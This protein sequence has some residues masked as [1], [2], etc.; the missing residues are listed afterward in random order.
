MMMSRF[1]A[2]DFPSLLVANATMG[3]IIDHEYLGIEYEKT[4][5]VLKETIERVIREDLR[6]AGLNVKYY[7]WTKINFNKD[8]TV[9]FS[10][11]SCA[12]TW[13]IFE[14]VRKERLLLLA[15]T[16]PDCPRLP[17]HEALTIPRIKIGVELPQILV[18]IRTSH[19]VNWKTAT[20]LYDDIFDRDT[21]SRVASSLSVESDSLAMSVSLLKLNSSTDLYERRENIKKS[22]ST[23]PTRSVGANFMVIATI[24]MTIIE[25]ATELNMINTASQWLF[26][27]SNPRKTNVTQLITYIKEGGNV[28]IATNNTIIDGSCSLGENCLYHE[29][30]KNFAMSLS[31]LVREEETIYS[32]ISDEEWESIRLTKRERRDNMLEFIKDR[33]RDVQQ[34]KPCVNWKFESAETWGLR[35][36]NTEGGK[37]K[38]FKPI[39]TY[40]AVWDPINGFVHYDNLFPHIAHGFRNRT[41]PIAI[42]HNPPWQIVS[43]N[44]AGEVKSM[45]GISVN[46]LNELAVK[47][48]FTYAVHNVE[49]SGNRTTYSFWDDFNVTADDDMKATFGL[50]S[51]VLELLT[52]NTVLFGAIAL[53]VH[54]T[55][56]KVLNFTFPISV[57]AYGMMIPRP[58]ELSRLYLFLSPFTVDT[59]VC[60]SLTMALIGPLFYVV[61]YLS[62]YHEHHHI[63]KKGGLFKIQNCFWYMYGALLQQGGM[64]LP[65]SD[66]GR[67]IVGTWWLVVLVVI[68]T[69][70]GNLVAFLTFPKMEIPVNTVGQLVNQK[71]GFT[72]SIRSNT[73]LESYLKETEIEKYVRLNDSTETHD[74]VTNGTISRVRGGKH[75]IIDWETNLLHIMRKEF[76][77]T[78]KCEFTLSNEKFLDEKI[79]LILPTNSPYLNI[80]NNEIYRMLQMGFIQKWLSEYLPKKDRC[81][82]KASSIEIE[83]H[84]VNLK[85]MQGCFLVLVIGIIAALFVIV[86]ECCCKRYRVLDET[87]LI[88]PFVK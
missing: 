38:A 85:D 6:G 64:Y 3:V 35:F 23:F 24:P 10:I 80:F 79:G 77:E 84:T 59:W 16:D 30:L 4:F 61:H 47:L 88:K 19:S 20:I 44:E 76:L 26:L 41:I 14:H 66:S 62:P 9:V 56:E 32:Q 11:A 2:N 25:V 37:L 39:L 21:I 31:K 1:S 42:Y 48:N 82:S 86:F 60:L 7:S 54:E 40:S 33:L 72:W 81:S 75:I 87:K 53:T 68:T 12:A 57:Q 34:C 43:Y 45:R 27:V 55:Y 74:S 71:H 22:L 15:I 13:E 5:E 65:R 50:P 17:L 28:A 46:I 8:F 51:D 63:T 69:Y 58:K 78:D 83:N 29:L 36:D 73:Y 67:I 70:C 49:R 52:E 18:D